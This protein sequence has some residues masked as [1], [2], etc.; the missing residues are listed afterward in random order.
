M[1]EFLVVWAI[2]IVT[3]LFGYFC[4]KAFEISNSPPTFKR[5]VSG[6]IKGGPFN[7]RYVVEGLDNNLH[8]VEPPITLTLED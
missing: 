5:I 1:I 2:I 7:G 6:P 8:Y 3:F 4:R